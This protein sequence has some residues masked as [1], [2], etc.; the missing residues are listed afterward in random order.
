MNAFKSTFPGI[1]VHGCHFHHG[2]SFY[3]KVTEL[4]IKKEYDSNPAFS[5][6][7]RTLLALSFVPPKEV[8]DYLEHIKEEGI[9]PLQ[10]LGLI[11]YMEDTYVGKLTSSGKRSKPYFKVKTWNC[12]EATLNDGDLTNNKTEAVFRSLQS[13]SRAK[14]GNI[15]KLL[16]LL[17]DDYVYNEMKYRQAIDGDDGNP[18]KKGYR[19]FARRRKAI[20]SE[21]AAYEKTEYLMAIATAI[22]IYY[23]VP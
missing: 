1:N 7:C 19:N 9:I 10:A 18:K 3:K 12:Y 22:E 2:Q 14:S 11:S 8:G 16:E 5:A 6:A 17:Q 13:D 23:V 4:G 15:W 20:V 21:I